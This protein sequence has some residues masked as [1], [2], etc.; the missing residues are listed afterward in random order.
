M[1]VSVKMISLV[2][3][4]IYL[5][6]DENRSDRREKHWQRCR[7]EIRRI[8]VKRM[9]SIDVRSD[10]LE[11]L[12]VVSIVTREI[13]FRRRQLCSEYSSFLLPLLYFL[14]PRECYSASYWVRNPAFCGKRGGKT[15]RFPREADISGFLRSSLW[16][17][18]FISECE[19]DDQEKKWLKGEKERCRKWWVGVAE[20]GK[21]V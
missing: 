1:K 21:E 13:S 6:H 5:C 14:F 9:E 4:N 3:T 12:Q 18:A 20:K 16:Q 8:C 7:K 17:G 11:K 2:Y 15:K 19:E 10:D